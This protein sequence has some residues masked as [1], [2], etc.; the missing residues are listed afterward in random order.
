MMQLNL[1]VCEGYG[2][3]LERYKFFTQ[4]HRHN[5]SAMYLWDD[6]FL[7]AKIYVPRDV[8]EKAI[9]KA[10]IQFKILQIMEYSI[11]SFEKS[12]R[13]IWLGLSSAT[14]IRP[15]GTNIGTGSVSG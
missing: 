11:Y 8:K 14:L 15:L 5:V 10:V 1:R 4:L 9:I 2:I 13:M 12:G 7:H 3:Y 6:Y